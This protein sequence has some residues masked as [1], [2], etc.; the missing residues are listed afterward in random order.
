MNGEDR[1]PVKTDFKS[2]AERKGQYT[3]MYCIIVLYAKENTLLLLVQLHHDPYINY[4]KGSRLPKCIV[5]KNPYPR[6]PRMMSKQ[7]TQLS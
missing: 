1:R 4:K 5:L 3:F 7:K 2:L 6:E